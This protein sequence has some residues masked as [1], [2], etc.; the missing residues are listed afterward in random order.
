MKSLVRRD[1][2]GNPANANI[3][4]EDHHSVQGDEDDDEEEHSAPQ[5]PAIGDNGFEVEETT[6]AS[7]MAASTRNG[8]LGGYDDWDN[9]QHDEP[10]STQTNQATA[11]DANLEPILSDEESDADM[12][13]LRDFVTQGE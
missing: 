10:E 1:I 13:D 4:E 7:A 12:Q 11:K 5:D 6:L 3:W 2:N 9:G 8:T